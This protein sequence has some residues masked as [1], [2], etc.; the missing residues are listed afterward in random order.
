M[1]INDILGEM[2]TR[3]IDMDFVK[4]MPKFDRTSMS[5]VGDIDGYGI[6]TQPSLT[7]NVF[8][9][10]FDGDKTALASLI[11]PTQFCGKDY[12][13]SIISQKYP[14]YKSKPLLSRLLFFY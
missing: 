9:V 1:R 8:Y 7:N 10:M 13:E 3:I 11:R 6:Y 14:N 12:A 2:T 4:A 5:H